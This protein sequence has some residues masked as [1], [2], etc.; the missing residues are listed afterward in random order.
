MSSLVRKVTLVLLAAGM[1]GCAHGGRPRL[2]AA[3]EAHARDR[4]VV[5]VVVGLESACA[6]LAGGDVVCF[7]SGYG[8]DFRES[9]VLR[10][11]RALV[12]G[13]RAC[14]IFSDGTAGCWESIPAD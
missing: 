6:L 2:I 9:V 8:L 4:D 13:P 12:L 1:A 7:G 5:D 11:A 3:A 14:A 10:N